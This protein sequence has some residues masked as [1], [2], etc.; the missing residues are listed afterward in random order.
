MFFGVIILGLSANL[1][2]T[3]AYGGA[4]SSTNFNVFVGIWIIV[5]ALIGFLENAISSLTGIIMTTLDSFSLLFTFAGAVVCSSL[6]PRHFSGFYHIDWEIGGIIGC[7]N[8]PTI[9]ELR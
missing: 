8:L 1:V 3:Q 6:S 2:V 4:P 9:R 5:I 7:R